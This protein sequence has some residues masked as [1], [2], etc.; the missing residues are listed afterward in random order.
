MSTYFTLGTS[1]VVQQLRLPASNARRAG[2][3]PGRGTKSYMPRNVAPQK[4][5]LHL[6][7]LGERGGVPFIIF[8]VALSYS[9]DSMSSDAGRKKKR[10][11]GCTHPME[12]LT[13]P[14][15]WPMLLLPHFH[16]F[17]FSCLFGVFCSAVL[18]CGVTPPEPRQGQRNS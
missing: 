5:T 8:C 6:G 12:L 2:S 18:Q 11:L 3:S 1:L 13:G 16:L 17:H 9:P 10:L 15:P 14:P 4:F 7:C